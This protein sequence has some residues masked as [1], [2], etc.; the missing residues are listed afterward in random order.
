MDKTFNFFKSKPRKENEKHRH[1][2]KSNSSKASCSKHSEKGRPALQKQPLTKKEKEIREA[3]EIRYQ[4]SKMRLY[5]FT[6]RN[7]PSMG[8]P[9]SSR[10]TEMDEFKH[11]RKK[12]VVDLKDYHTRRD[13]QALSAHSSQEKKKFALRFKFRDSGNSAVMKTEGN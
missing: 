13:S 1:H 10:S 7:E 6:R 12:G 5:Q 3:I 2:S 4:K 8:R 11:L 9:A